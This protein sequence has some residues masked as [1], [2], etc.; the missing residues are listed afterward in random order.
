LKQT[1]KSNEIQYNRGM[2]II[3]QGTVLRAFWLVA[4]FGLVGNTVLRCVCVRVVS[5]VCG[6]H[7]QCR[8]VCVCECVCV[9]CF[10]THGDLWV[11]W[12][13]DVLRCV[14]EYSWDRERES[15]CVCT[16]VLCAWVSVV[17]VCQCHCQCV[18]QFFC[19]AG[20]WTRGDF[21]VGWERGAEVCVGERVC[22]WVCLCVWCLLVFVV[23][24]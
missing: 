14:C 12:E 18:C 20:F 3:W 1:K 10:W 11:S 15:V 19:V 5:V 23:N 16:C 9:A 2:F 21:R 4:T 8:C 24:V 7:C 22:V 17:C 6:C 13:H